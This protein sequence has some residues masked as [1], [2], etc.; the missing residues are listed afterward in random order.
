MV[1]KTY[2]II[3]DAGLHARPGSLLVGTV[4]PFISEVK[5]EH[6]DKQ[7]NMKSIMSLMSLGISKGTDIK[8]IA[9]GTDEESLMLKIDELLE[10]EGLAVPS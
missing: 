10:K 2:K 5:L 8:I 7:V 1:E 4:T 3:S 6:K 9:N